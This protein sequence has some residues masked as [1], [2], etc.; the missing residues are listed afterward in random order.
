MNYLK[1]QSYQSYSCLVYK[2]HGEG[3]ADVHH[4]EDEEEDEDVEGDVGDADDHG[5]RLTPHQA[6]LQGKRGQVLKTF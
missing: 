3:E 2:D 4:D 5:P 1:L 6:A